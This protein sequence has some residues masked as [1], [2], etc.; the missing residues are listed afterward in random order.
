[1][2]EQTERRLLRVWLLLSGITVVSWWLGSERAGSEVGSSSWVTYVALLIV[3]VKVR[4]IVVELMEAR[5]ASPRLQHAMDAWLFL[6]V[7]SLGAIYA[8]K[9]GMPPV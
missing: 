2:N 3:A 8:L 5:R 4:V 7:V 9:L 6:L 1:M